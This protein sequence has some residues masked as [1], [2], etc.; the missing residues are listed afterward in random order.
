MSQNEIDDEPV[1]LQNDLINKIAQSKNATPAQILIAWS[2]QRGNAVIPKSVTPSRI[3]ENIKA[4][5]IQLTDSQMEEIEKID[6][7]YRFV[8]G[9]F[10][11]MDGSPY[12]MKYLWG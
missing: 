9:S 5:D 11:A 1:L 6:R 4:Q 12:T 7:A 3:E 2:A 10:W 8:D